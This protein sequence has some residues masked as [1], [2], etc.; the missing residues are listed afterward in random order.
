MIN[1]KA[2]G[3]KGER[4]L[5]AFFNDQGWVCIRAAGSGSS[6]YPAPDLL[7]GNAIRRL[8]IE[9]KVTKDE[10]K[11]FTKEEINQLQT[12]AQKFGAEPWVA[13]H[14]PGQPWHFCML[15]DL[16]DTG[17]SFCLSLELARFKGLTKEQLLGDW[18]KESTSFK[19][20]TTGQD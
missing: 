20:T 5:V 13:V 17:A 15:E 1:T 11:Y 8:A 18:Q 12:F 3:T 2:K 7:A 10:K 9:C 6:R 16:K 4:E 14:F 19:H